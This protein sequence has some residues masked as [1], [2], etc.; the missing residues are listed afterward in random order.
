MCLGLSSTHLLGLK[1]EIF[2]KCQ[3]KIFR[4]FVPVYPYR[5]VKDGGDIAAQSAHGHCCFVSNV[6]LNH[7]SA[8][9]SVHTKGSLSISWLRLAYYLTFLLISTNCHCATK[10][11]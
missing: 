8:L 5:H 3:V 6:K 4:N 9:L 10:G 1:M 2:L 11:K 7:N